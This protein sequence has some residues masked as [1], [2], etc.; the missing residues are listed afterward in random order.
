MK[1]TLLILTCLLSGCASIPSSWDV[2]LQTQPRTS[3]GDTPPQALSSMTRLVINMPQE[4]QTQAV[5]GTH[6]T[7]IRLMYTEGVVRVAG[8]NLDYHIGLTAN[9]GGGYR[10]NYGVGLTSATP[11]IHMRYQSAL[12]ADD[13]VFSGRTAATSDVAINPTNVDDSYL[14]GM[15]IY[16]T[17][18][19]GADQPAQDVFDNTFETCNTVAETGSPLM[20]FDQ[21]NQAFVNIFKGIKVTKA[22][23]STASISPIATAPAITSASCFIVPVSRRLV[24]GASNQYTATA[25]YYRLVVPGGTKQIDFG[26]IPLGRM[27]VDVRRYSDQYRIQSYG[28]GQWQLKDNLQVLDVGELLGSTM[29]DTPVVIS[30]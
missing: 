6:H 15:G 7:E 30:L 18:I 26:T 9:T 28:Y 23:N 8:E 22:D 3:G 25:L 10:F 27:V 2:F 1:N 14:L 4:Y 29:T 24:G 12:T 11:P 13:P 19:P 21:T 5:M 20:L 17:F 16:K